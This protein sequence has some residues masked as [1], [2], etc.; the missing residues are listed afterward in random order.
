M[1][2]SSPSHLSSASP[3]PPSQHIL[4]MDQSDAAS[5][6]GSLAFHLAQNNRRKDMHGT[7]P[8]R[9]RVEGVERRESFL[10]WWSQVG[11]LVLVAVPGRA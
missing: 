2:V 1:S 9:A 5:E 8:A 11:P 7:Q 10:P 3:R 6:S 4:A